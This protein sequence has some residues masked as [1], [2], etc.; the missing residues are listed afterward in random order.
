MKTL[1]VLLLAVLLPGSA[2]AVD[3]PVAIQL[4]PRHGHATPDHAGCT[5]TAGGNIIVAQ[6]AADV[7]IVTMTGVAV[8]TGHP[9]SDSHA[10]MNFDLTQDF[11][12]VFNDAKLK[13]A[14]LQ[15]EAQVIGL[16]RSDASCFGQGASGHG[17]G[18]GAA[19]QAEA[20]AAISSGPAAITSLCVD[21][22][23]VAGG[24]NLSLNCRQGPTAVP[25]LEGFY[26]LHQTFNVLASHPRCVLPSK[27]ASAEFA[28]D[29]LDPQWI[30]YWEPFRGVSKKDF[31]FQVTIHVSA[32]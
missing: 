8:A 22:H 21:P 9:F 32:D 20:C 14:K 10:G 27:P 24:E 15:I 18:C 29:A 31:G 12:V 17:K 28:P 23:A 19:Q 1:G 5:H 11:K 30:S 2:W 16:L 4:A 26:T 3:P 13:K 7:V 25:I 6:P